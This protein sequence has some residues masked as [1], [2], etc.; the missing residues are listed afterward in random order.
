MNTIQQPMPTGALGDLSSPDDTA[1]PRERGRVG[2]GAL[3]AM[4]PQRGREAPPS[5][6]LADVHAP[7]RPREPVTLRLAEGALERI[8]SAFG[9]KVDGKPL[10]LAQMENTPIESM[11]L[12]AALLGIKSLGDTANLKSLAL[13]IRAKG[14]E[15]LR[16]RQN[17]DLRKQID[18]SI[19][20]AQKAKKA[21]IFAVIVDWIVA[22]AEVVSG[23]AKIMVGDVAGGAMDLAAGCAGL[24]KAMCETLAQIDPDN[25]DR[26]KEVADIAGK[27][28]LAFEIAGM[29]VD[30][31]SV[32][33]GMMAAKS[34]GKAT[35]TVM[36]KGSGEALHAAVKLGGEAGGKAAEKVAAEIG[37]TVAEQ[38]SAQVA[39]NLTEGITR[40]FGQGQL[41]QAFSKQ[42]IENMVTKA[43]KTV[44]EQAIKSGAEITAQQLAKQVVKEVQREI[45]K[46]VVKACM[47]S[48]ANVGKAVT[49]AGVQGANGVLQGEISRERAE[50]QKIIQQLIAESGYMQILLDDFE[51]LKKRA[52]EDIGQLMESAGKALSSG[53]DAQLKT[54]A[55]LSSIAANIA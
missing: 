27:V 28:Q 20:D 30:A 24:V 31:V 35:G 43:V 7:A 15:D 2:A 8:L 19:E 41:L 21:G 13:E 49:R 38:V 44:A 52:R 17:E 11:G 34:I 9:P 10:T 32:G 39:K 33:R 12:A 42:A 22:A 18:Q 48:A 3:G 46:A 54:G 5:R 37:K 51:R 1:E 25:A 29:M 14:A 55:L 23:V 16:L 45:I 50:L 40:F 47:M 4:S 6:P 53:S 36:E 26:Y